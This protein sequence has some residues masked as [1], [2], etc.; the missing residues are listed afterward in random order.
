MKKLS[1]LVLVAFVFNILFMQAISFADEVI[2][3]QLEQSVKDS[4]QVVKDQQTKELSED[5]KFKTFNSC[6]DMEKVMTD[7]LS[8]YKNYYY[9]PMYYMMEDAV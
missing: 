4:E 6:D 5:F 3:K 1:F 7:F 9:R 2:D 8:S